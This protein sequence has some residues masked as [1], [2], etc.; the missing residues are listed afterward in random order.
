SFVGIQ[1]SGPF[2]IPGT[3]ARSFLQAPL[4]PNGRPNSD[5]LRPTVNGSDVVA[6][7]RDIWMIDFPRGLDEATASLY[8]QPFE[9]LR[10]TP[11]DAERPQYGT[12]RKARANARDREPRVQWWTTYWPRPELRSALSGLCRYIVTPMTAEHR[13]FVW[14]TLPL[15]PDNN[16]IIFAAD[17]D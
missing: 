8:E 13:V 16:T 3:L 4:N 2:D 1:K 7:R 6:S 9:Y 10:N 14:R 15:I 5:V 12:L 17:D 11:Y